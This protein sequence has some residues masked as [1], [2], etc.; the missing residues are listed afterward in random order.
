VT[1]WLER[2][3][4]SQRRLAPLARTLFDVPLPGDAVFDDLERLAHNLVAMNGILRDRS[5][6][7]VRLVTSPDRMVVKEAMR[8]FTY[9]NLYGFLTDAVVVNRVLPAEAADGY[10]AEWREVQREQMELVR[11]AFEPVPIL[12]AP[13]F[14]REVIGPRMLDRLADKVFD[15]AD[16]AAV[17]H[18]D[19][20]QELATENGRARLRLALPFADRSRLQLKKIGLEVVVRVGG[21]KRT[22]ILPPALTGYAARGARLEDGALEITFEKSDD[23]HRA[24]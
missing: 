20:S 5:H 22:I 16:P 6:T 14:E 2:I 15:D 8:T 1:W 9:L 17:L 21:Q 24:R 13:L 10:F 12:S 4:P 23:E 18:E 11:S 3:L 7:T 19:I